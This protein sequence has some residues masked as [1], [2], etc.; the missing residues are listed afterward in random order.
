MKR[1]LWIHPGIQRTATT[2]IQEFFFENFHA[3]QERG[4]LYPFHTRRHFQFMNRL[5]RGNLQ[6]DVAAEDLIRRADA[7]STPIHTLVLSDEAIS[8]HKNISRLTELRKYFDVKI[9][10]FLR[11]QDLWL[12]S[13]YFQ[14]VKWQWNPAL[15]HGTLED[16]LKH[17]KSFHWIHYDKHIARLEKLFGPENVHIGVFERQDMPG[18]PVATFCNHIGLTQL[19]GLSAPKHTNASLSPAMT[20]LVRQLPLDEG[21]GDETRN[22]MVQAL[23]RVDAHLPKRLSGGGKLILPHQTRLKIMKR[24]AK[25]NAA[26]A[27][28]R[29]GR[30]L[31]FQEPLPDP[32]VPIADLALPTDS[33]VLMEYFIGPLIGD[34][35]RSGAIQTPGK[36]G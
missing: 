17:Q 26:L 12:E 20:D 35:I 18:G 4:I 33:A 29:F 16:F 3:L 5:I 31:L 1:T 24:Y 34:L 8:L 30:D 7:K 9:M 19:D 21:L 6:V 25:G 15:S 11:R 14:N 2:S 32:S 22:V 28:R 27:K 10:L 13:W 36:K 23:Q